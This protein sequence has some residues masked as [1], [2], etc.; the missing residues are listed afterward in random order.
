MCRNPKA[1]VFIG[2]VLR[3][4]LVKR[5]GKSLTLQKIEP[6]YCG[7]VHIAYTTADV[8]AWQYLAMVIPIPS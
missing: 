7:L 5:N 2:H 6:R 8:R 1:L 4:Y 3:K